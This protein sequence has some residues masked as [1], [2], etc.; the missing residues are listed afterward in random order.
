MELSSHLHSLTPKGHFY[1]IG[2]LEICAL[3]WLGTLILLISASWVAGITGMSHR[4]L[5]SLAS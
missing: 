3:G 1:E 2:S 5:V 4:C